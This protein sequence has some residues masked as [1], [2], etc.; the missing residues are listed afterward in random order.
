VFFGKKSNSR[1]N[2]SLEGIEFTDIKEDFIPFA[3]H[4]SSDTIITKNIQALQT[5][6]FS[7]FLFH[8]GDGNLKN[9]IREAIKQ[10][11]VSDDFAIWLHTIR[12]RVEFNDIFTSEEENS[13]LMAEKWNNFNDF[14]DEFINELYLTFVVKNPEIKDKDVI[15][16]YFT[17]K[18]LKNFVFKELEQI[19]VNL[20]NVVDGII[21]RLSHYKPLKLGVV[22]RNGVLYS[23]N[24]E[25]F[26]KILNIAEAEVRLDEFD[27]SSLLASSKIGL[28]SNKINIV[29]NLGN[30]SI[31]V[32]TLKYYQ[33]VSSNELKKIFSLPFEF[34]IY[35]AIDFMED[36]DDKVKYNLQAQMLK[37][38]KDETLQKTLDLS[39]ENLGALQFA[40]SQISII[41]I[42]ESEDD[43]DFKTSQFIASLEDTGFVFVR[44][45]IMIEDA[46]FGSI[47]A[48]FFFLKRMTPIQAS[49]IGGFC[50]IDKANHNTPSVNTLC[51]F[52]SLQDKAYFYSITKEGHNLFI[53]KDGDIQQ[54]ALS[55]FLILNSLKLNYRVISI[56]L[57][58]SSKLF[59]AFIGGEYI[60]SLCLNPSLFMQ[61]EGDINA[62]LKLALELNNTLTD[63]NLKYAQEKL[64]PFILKNQDKI[65]TLPDLIS[66]INNQKVISVFFEK[67]KDMASL[68]TLRNDIL[69]ITEGKQIGI[70]ITG[71][72]QKAKTGDFLFKYLLLL[73]ERL[74]R[75]KKQ[76]IIKIDNFISLC[77]NA[78][79]DKL[80]IFTLLKKF[81]QNNAIIFALES[82][83]MFEYYDITNE[84]REIMNL[85]KTT[86][87]TPA[88]S[89]DE[90]TPI[91]NNYLAKLR[92]V[93]N[94]KNSEVGDI[95]KIKSDEGV[96]LVRE[97]STLT[98]LLFSPNFS[99]F[100]YFFLASMQN[101][102][103]IIE[104][105]N[106]SKNIQDRLKNAQ[107]IHNILFSKNGEQE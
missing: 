23:Q 99:H 75:D 36:I 41:I 79:F 53:G 88:F 17:H 94:L 60:A 86:F 52:K 93:Q 28:F 100:Y 74:T 58:G 21:Q 20:S 7:D 8:D 98:P 73:I 76:T 82:Y 44:E 30:K 51:A 1:T 92:K 47:P 16:K 57:N 103:A 65:K 50:G 38:S 2:I 5:V 90:N 80:E 26:H 35:Q 83:K 91:D 69:N 49:K 84:D 12:R 89:D 54:K 18:K 32:L 62:F 39:G 14:K 9:D 96:F 66:I 56:D 37:I 85:F 34:I 105:L 45:D 78:G 46:F 10:N 25:F 107:I 72:L 102:D 11:I 42:G 71:F 33:D 19:E 3:C 104:R 101:E 67:L 97:N 61:N 22:E 13:R 70:D 48:N 77:F 81:T 68:T 43:A 6:K 87:Y 55:N 40:R 29:N 64:T 31:A 106:N 27:I 63:G 4:I 95:C 15:T 24:I 59:N